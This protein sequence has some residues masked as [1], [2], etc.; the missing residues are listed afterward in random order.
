MSM[1][2]VVAELI[3]RGEE[4]LAEELLTIA[5]K[6]EPKVQGKAKFSGEME[7]GSDGTVHIDL[8]Q[9]SGLELVGQYGGMGSYGA[10]VAS[11]LAS[12]L[13]KG[14]VAHAG[15]YGNGKVIL[16]IKR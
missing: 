14:K 8:R 4:E 7:I 10:E 1:A 5:A 6:N 13:D 9:I 2:K 16:S 11:G 15:A 3:K 12:L